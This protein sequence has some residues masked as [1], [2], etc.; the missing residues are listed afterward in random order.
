VVG[1][2]LAL[3]IVGGIGFSLGMSANVATS[4]AAVAYPV[5]G[6]GFGFPFFPIFGLIFG[7]FF[8]FLIF[9]LVGR[10]IRGGR[11]G[12]GPRGHWMDA[13]GGREMPSWSGKP[14]PPFADEMLRR[15]HEQ[16]HGQPPAAHKPDSANPA[17]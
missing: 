13:Q 7:V 8:L 2:L 14:V 1:G 4:G 15:W 9:G 10:A 11:H 5:I 17:G 6:W 16:A 12:Y 3:L